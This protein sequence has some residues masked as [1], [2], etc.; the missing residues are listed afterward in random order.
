M[1]A[2]TIF[3]GVTCFMLVASAA[4]A[5]LTPNKRPL[6]ELFHAAN[7]PSNDGNC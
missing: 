4:L 5:A 3:L 7:R 1:D 2:L 6:S